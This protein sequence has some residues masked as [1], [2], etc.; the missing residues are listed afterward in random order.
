MSNLNIQH[1]FTSPV[2]VVKVT[3]KNLEEVAAWC[4]GKVART[5]SRRVKGRV[6]SY[7]WVP[8]PKGSVISW[9][10]PGMYITKRLAVTEK[11][12]LKATFSVFRKDYFSKNYF[13]NPTKAVDATWEREDKEKKKASRQA[14]TI[15]IV[16]DEDEDIQ[17][18]AAKLQGVLDGSYEAV[19]VPAVPEEVEA[20]FLQDAGDSLPD[21]M[22]G[23]RELLHEEAVEAE[24]ETELELD[25]PIKDPARA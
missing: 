10:F 1:Y 15:T 11:N 21:S 17:E 23:Q 20:E 12:E 18:T 2:E 19:P 25:D 16:V 22:V 4:G 5:E 13:E 8:T 6:D 9:A 14:R 7:V 3:P 24:S